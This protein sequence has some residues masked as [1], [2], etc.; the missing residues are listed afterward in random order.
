[1]RV[2][3]LMHIDDQLPLANNDSI[4]RDAILTMANKPFGCIGVI[5]DAGNLQGII[6]DGDLRRHMS[7]DLMDKK[8]KDIMTFNP[9]T[10]SSD[11]LAAEVIAL[12]NKA[13]ISAVF[14][15]EDKKPIGIVHLHDFLRAGVV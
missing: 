13:K 4:M 6:T 14:I 8:V 2:G 12:M 11:N 5:C 3:D 1:M 15:V 10:I 7:N 9:I